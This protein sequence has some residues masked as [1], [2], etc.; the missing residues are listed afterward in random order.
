MQLKRKKERGNFAS[1]ILLTGCFMLTTAN[2]GMAQ[3]AKVQLDFTRIRQ[4]LNGTETV[5]SGTAAPVPDVSAGQMSANTVAPTVKSVANTV[6]AGS[7]V[8]GTMDPEMN[9]VM[10]DTM[11]DGFVSSDIMAEMQKKVMAENMASIQESI[12]ASVM[13]SVQGSIQQTAK[14]SMAK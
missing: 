3:G 10:G 2:A 8:I 7:A 6:Q 9:Q 14:G 12:Q 13:K 5:S 1:A 4:A 11:R